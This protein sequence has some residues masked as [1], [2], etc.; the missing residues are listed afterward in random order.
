ME[1]NQRSIKVQHI[2]VVMMMSEALVRSSHTIHS[3]LRG[4]LL[5]RPKCAKLGP[6]L[7]QG[8]IVSLTIRAETAEACH[9]IDE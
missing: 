1:S 8:H 2:V 3:P 7:R 6:V 4:F 5:A 9:P